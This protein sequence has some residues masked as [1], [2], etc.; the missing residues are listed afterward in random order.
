MIMTPSPRIIVFIKGFE[1]CRL[2]AYMPTPHDRPTIGW[3]TTGNDVRLGMTW[4]Q[5]QCDERFARDLDDFAAGVNHELHG[6]QTT[7]GQFDALLSFAYN[8]GLDDDAD[9]LAEGLGDS[10]LLKK[11]LAGDYVGAAAE[12]AK[13]NKQAGV[14]LAGLT[15]RRAAEAAI[16]S[17]E[18]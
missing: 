15:R 7:Q 18:N 3:G 6:A 4:T 12:F 2:S 11:H 10:T 16:Y 14:V 1:M 9:T 17:G 5:K 13:W 8:V